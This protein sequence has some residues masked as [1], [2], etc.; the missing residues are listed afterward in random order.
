MKIVIIYNQDLDLVPNRLGT[1]NKEIYPEKTIKTIKEALISLGHKVYIADGNQ[2]IIAE[3]QSIIADDNIIPFAFNIS[4]G[5]QGESRYTH[6]PALLEM[7]GI[8]YTGS[9][10]TGHTL[11]LNKAVTKVIWKDKNIPTPDF[12]VVKKDDN[13]T[14]LKYSNKKYPVIVK[15]IMES[16]SQGLSIANN[17]TELKNTLYKTIDKFKQ[18]ILVE[19][20]IPG[21]EFTVSILGNNS[22]I[23]ILPITEI[24]FKGNPNAIYSIEDK[25]IYSR[26]KRCPANISQELEHRVKEISK[27]AYQVIGIK[28]YARIDIR[29]D[30]EGNLFLLEINAMASLKEESSLPI[31]AKAAGYTYKEL[32]S[33][34]LNVAIDRY[35]L[36]QVI[37]SDY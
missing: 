5:I 3:L 37:H 18:D 7:L 29:M 25:L 11:A 6:I 2:N 28:D 32:I 26:Q 30:K 36:K 31:A 23:E 19:Q 14:S 9:S 20:F 17:K 22:S 4:Y 16:V 8:P 13:I 10:P 12:M 21:R 24:D 15:P 1:Q 33:K 35:K 27:K 34:I